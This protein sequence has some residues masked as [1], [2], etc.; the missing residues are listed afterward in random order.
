MTPLPAHETSSMAGLDDFFAKKDK[1][2]KGKRKQF[3]TS[4]SIAK[5]LEVRDSGRDKI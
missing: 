1:R 4:N 3:P 2:K 5:A